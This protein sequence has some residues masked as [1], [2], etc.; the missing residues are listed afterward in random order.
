M[1]DFG[2]EPGEGTGKRHFDAITCLKYVHDNLVVH[3]DI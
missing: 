1:L 3:G 2:C